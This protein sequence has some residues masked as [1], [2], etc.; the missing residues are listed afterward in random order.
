MFG[1][2][3]P[4]EAKLTHR[5][6]AVFEAY[7]CR[8]CYCL[9]IVGGQVA[10][11]CTTYD[12]AIYAMIL[13]LQ[14]GEDLPPVLPCE[15]LG[16]KFKKTFRDNA[17]GIK[18][19]R[20]SLI[21]FGEKIRDDE[22]DNGRGFKTGLVSLPLAKAL[23][24]AREAEPKMAKDSYEGTE[25]INRLQNANAPL[26]EILG[27]YGDMSVTSF[28]E[29][30]P[31]TPKTEELIRAVS[32]WNFLVDMV[33]DYDDDYKN[34]TYNGFKKE[35][36]PTLSAYFDRYYEEFSAVANRISDR[37]VV[38]LTAVRDDSVVWNTLFKICIHAIDNVLTSAVLGE[39]VAYHYFREV[40]ARMKENRRLEK[41]IKRLGITKQ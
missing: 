13:A 16:T 38:A 3:R 7:Y 26:H 27:A 36:V 9:R 41:D 5:E 29:F 6:R 28:S 34:G 10:R 37:F 14:S 20:L 31:L 1:Y 23:R 15:R 30:F 8:T 22:M 21:S 19:A 18:L 17:D 24:E 33:C 40:F 2:F 39:D 35:G 4:Y 12:A 32:E 25:R 11:F